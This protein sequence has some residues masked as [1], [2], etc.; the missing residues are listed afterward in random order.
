M[1][2]RYIRKHGEPVWIDLTVSL[3][4]AATGEPLY[5]ICVIEDISDRKHTDEQLRF[6]AQASTL[7][8]SSLDY[9]TTLQRVAD[10]M[11]PNLADW[12]A[13]DVLQPGGSIELVAVAHVDPEMAAWA[14]ELRQHYPPHIDDPGGLAQ[15]IRTGQSEFYPE[16]PEEL[17]AAA[18]ADG[19]SAA[20][21]QKIGFRSVIIVPLPTREKILGGI[22]LVW[23][24]TD[25]RYNEIDL[26]FAEELAR[27]A[28]L[29]VENARLYGEAREA[30]AELRS[31]NETLEQ[32]VT[33]RT[34][35]LERR[36]RELDQFAYVASHDLKAPL[37][38][39][40][41]LATWITED[42]SN[43]L[44]ESS[45]RHLRTMR[46][47]V[48]RM[49]ELLNDLLTYSRADRLDTKPVEVDTGALVTDVIELL[50]PPP[51]FTIIVQSNLPT[52]MAART[53]L[54]IVF[55]NLIDNAIKHHHRTDGRVEISARKQK[56]YI[57]FSVVDDGPGI[58][59]LFHE[60]IFQMFQTLQPRDRVEG[61]G[62]GL[63]VV[64]KV[65]E[66][67]GGAISVASTEGY[68]STFSFT[69]PIKPKKVGAM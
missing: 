49:E 39:I 42:A 52:I 19:E 40:D 55:R 21:I 25:R 20:I 37:R 68:G 17:L 38:A 46:G 23:S 48:K 51:D 44:P 69:W 66:S 43:I 58:D 11:V 6:L 4:Y 27:R 22:T 10:L 9:Q 36:N 24:D 28:A 15:V 33:E 30:E 65:V 60:R 59:P 32:R 13:V 63:A 5:C 12:C 56:D 62:M 26:R 1:E 61:S 31:L 3:Q 14:R 34:E 16:I 18:M 8:A 35:E 67:Q 7:L 54:E 2:K 45:M 64:K 53:P 29:A 47:R 57:E 50:A 41:N